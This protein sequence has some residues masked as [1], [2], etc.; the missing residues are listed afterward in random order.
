[1]EDELWDR[2]SYRIL[3]KHTLILNGR[4]KKEVG[5]EYLEMGLIPSLSYPVLGFIDFEANGKQIRLAKL[6]SI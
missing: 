3:R 5:K 2:F 4:S 1:M 6:G